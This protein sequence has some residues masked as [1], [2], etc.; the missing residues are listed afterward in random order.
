V[1]KLSAV[2][3]ADMNKF[4][5]A[6]KNLERR[7]IYQKQEEFFQNWLNQLRTNAKIEINKDLLSL[8]DPIRLCLFNTSLSGYPIRTAHLN[9]LHRFKLPALHGGASEA[10]LG[11]ENARGNG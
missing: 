10:C 9:S 8:N 4:S 1:V 5:A 11:K 6:K 2:E 7:L 3:Q